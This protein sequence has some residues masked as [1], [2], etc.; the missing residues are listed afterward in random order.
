MVISGI[1]GRFPQ[2]DN[3]K[4]FAH[5]LYAKRDLVDDRELRW[6]H[7]MPGVPKRSG[8]VN[9]LDKFDAEFFGIDRCLRDTMDPQIRMLLEHSFEAILDAGVNPET[10]RGSRTGVFTASIFSETQMRMNY[11]LCPPKGLGLLG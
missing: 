8:K 11:M 7:D 6:T 9:N 2:T 3:V 10:I 1:S 5:N 4:D